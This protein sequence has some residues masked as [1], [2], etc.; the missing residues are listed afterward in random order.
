M[1]PAVL[2]ALLYGPAMAGLFALAQRVVGL[3]VRLFSDS[4]SQAFLGEIATADRRRLH[5]LFKKTTLLFLGI[6]VVGML[7]LLL[8]GPPSSPSSSA[9][10]GGK[11][12]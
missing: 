3:P 8:A 12:G 11:P 6:G 10:R 4:A 7:P 9:R 2:I 1:L 5:Q